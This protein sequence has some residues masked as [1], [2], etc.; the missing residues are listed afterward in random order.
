MRLMHT[1]HMMQ[2]QS[3]PSGPPIFPT[4]TQKKTSVSEP[5]TQLI[6]SPVKQLEGK[7][8]SIR[9]DI[10]SDNRSEKRPRPDTSSS[11]ECSTDTP[12]FGST[13]IFQ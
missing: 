8:E 11:L 1:Y 3:S 10:R 13:V 5:N 6:I 4:S 9:S 2:S 7:G 12:Q